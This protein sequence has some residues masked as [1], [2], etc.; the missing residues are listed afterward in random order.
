MY[1]SMY[2]SNS[3][4]RH[5]MLH[6]HPAVHSLLY[7]CRQTWG[8]QPTLT[9]LMLAILLFYCHTTHRG[10]GALESSSWMIPKI[11]IK[12]VGDSVL[13]HGDHTTCH[14]KCCDW[15]HTSAK[16]TARILKEAETSRTTYWRH[17]E[18]WAQLIDSCGHIVH[19]WL[20]RMRCPIS[21]RSEVDFKCF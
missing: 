13:W 18:R 2:W 1:L 3:M 8:F 16:L 9:L 11:L 6:L 4:L 5:F 17:R 14:V 7:T 19:T 10:F 15:T 12:N 21:S 20:A